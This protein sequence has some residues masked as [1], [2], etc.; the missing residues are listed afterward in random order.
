MTIN[1]ISDI[2]AAYDEQAGKVLYHFPLKHTEE[3]YIEAIEQLCAYWRDN[4][5][6]I[7]KLQSKASTRVHSYPG[8]FVVKSYASGMK[9]L[10]R[11]ARSAKARF[12]TTSLD[13]MYEFSRGLTN[14]DDFMF[15]NALDWR[16]GKT[17]LTIKYDL[18]DFMFKKIGDFEPAKLK[19]ADYLIIAG[20]IG[21]DNT[22]TKILADL[23][24]QTAGKFKKIL[25]IAGN[26]D[27]WWCSNDASKKPSGV[28][29]EHDYFEHED[30]DFLFLGCTL[31]TPISDDSMWIVGRYM[32]DYR[33]TP[34]F[35]PF[36]SREQY[37]QQSKWLRARVA[38]NPDKKIIVFTHHQ[39]FEELTADDY[40][41][42]GQKWGEPDVNE[43][44]VVMDHS[45]DD[46]N[47]LGNIKLW[48]CGH[49]HLPYDGMLHDVHVVRNPIG[50]GDTHGCIPAENIKSVEH[51][52]DKI[53]EI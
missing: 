39:P 49:T 46:I 14:I 7:K 21:Y 50:Y 52:Y 12:E 1:I 9:L 25:H 51:W 2:H 43:A 13:E 10:S 34:S 32:N 3:R 41:H 5:S 33:Y 44:Y 18:K 30:S 15:D 47:K 53:I 29:L 26:H 45:L 20:D 48:C 11:F 35:S 22:Y 27:H 16:Q 8:L 40:K 24:K 42:N 4:A 36:A 28:N 19:P 37:A 31:W 38:A 6:S 17:V 23:E